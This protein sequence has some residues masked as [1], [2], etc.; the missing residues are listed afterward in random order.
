VQEDKKSWRPRAGPNVI[1]Q[2]FSQAVGDEKADINSGD[3][4][5]E[6]S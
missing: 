2:H 5:E 3:E 4:R 6:D 1:S